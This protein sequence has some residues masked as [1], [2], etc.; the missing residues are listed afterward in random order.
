MCVI[1]N[2]ETNCTIRKNRQNCLEEK[3]IANGK[4]VNS[5]GPGDT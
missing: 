4:Q 3:R 2:Y 1:L 5:P